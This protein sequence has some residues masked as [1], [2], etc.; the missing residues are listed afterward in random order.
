MDDKKRST[1][2]PTDD[3]ARRTAVNPISA[4][5][6]AYETLISLEKDGK[7]SNIAVGNAIK[8]YSFS[9]K[10]RDLYTRLVY[11]TLEKR[12]TL[13]YI[14]QKCSSKPT[15]N[16]DLSVLIILRL[17]AY[18]IKFCEKIPDSAAVNEGVKLA[19]RYASRAVGFVNAVLRCISKE[20]LPLPSAGSDLAAYLSVA[21][22]VDISICRMLVHQ[23]GEV[24][25]EKILSGFGEVPRICLNVNTHRTKG[26]KPFL[27]FCG[28]DASPCRY[29][30][31]G[32][33]VNGNMSVSESECIAEGTAF[34]QGEAS[35]LAVAALDPR[36]DMLVIDVCACPGGKS[37][38][39]ANFMHCKGRILSLDIHENKLN[40]ILEG[41]KHLG[42]DNIIS[43]KQHD[44]TSAIKELIGKADRVICDVP[45]SGFGVMAKKPELRYK[46]A[47]E[48]ASLPPIQ[49]AILRSASSYLSDG[50]ILVYSTCTLNKKENEEVV[51]KFLGENP[52]FSYVDFSFEDRDQTAPLSSSKGMLTLLPQNGTDGFFI[53][54]IRRKGA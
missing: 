51:E 12:I 13:D 46:R 30:K 40:L 8:K 41:A 54:K 45:C 9:G 37:F 43:V 38:A 14:V 28:L 25:A 3:K 39:A 10:D 29:S 18:Q 35:Q 47:D 2:L 50:G 6:A 36:E 7:F 42:Y 19:K 20:Q 11:G 32:V 24:E 22:S 23:Y 27:D 26:V 44:G 48:I 53:A 31:T 33:I 21:Y 17:S 15:K 49:Y 34:V 16:L 52:D 5:Q 1:A 4:R